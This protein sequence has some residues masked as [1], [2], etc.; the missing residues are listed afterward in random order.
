MGPPVGSS[1][2]QMM[3]LKTIILT[4]YER[5]PSRIAG[6]KV[7]IL[8]FVSFSSYWSSKMLS[9]TKFRKRKAFYSIFS[10]LLLLDRFFEN[11]TIYFS[12]LP[13]K[14]NDHP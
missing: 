9:H 1:N 7:C 3:L 10:G 12:M 8:S 11:L 4:C 6:K 5:S 2:L 14:S 13:T